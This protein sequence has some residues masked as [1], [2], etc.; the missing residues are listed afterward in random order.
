[1]PVNRLPYFPFHVDDYLNDSVVVAMNADA[2]GCYVRL[3]LRSWRSPTPGRIPV[4]LLREMCGAHRLAEQY[5]VVPDTKLQLPELGAARFGEVLLQMAKAF[6]TESEPD[7]WIQKRMVEEFRHATRQGEAR[8][9]GAAVTNE[10]RWGKVA[11]PSPS[12]R[13][14]VGILD[15]EVEVEVDKDLDPNTCPP[16]E[17]GVL[18]LVPPEPKPRPER[19]EWDEGFHEAFW[20]AYP[21]KVKRADALKA[22]RQQRPWTQKN[23]DAICHGLE[24]WVAYWE[25][26][27][28]ELDKIPY[29]A[30]FLRAKQYEGGPQ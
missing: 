9:K 15:L 25:N 13:S 16:V 11:K 7:T 14:A 10:K 29:P 26:R 5:R 27:G 17:G 20:P 2:E 28:M 24:Q 6:D 30:T 21:R 19:D 1:M 8:K 23:M 18:V 12:V 22:W 4:R 3:L